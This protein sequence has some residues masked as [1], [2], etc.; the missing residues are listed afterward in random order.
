MWF[1]SQLKQTRTNED[2]LINCSKC[3]PPC[4]CPKWITQKI[5]KP[6]NNV[7]HWIT[8]VVITIVFCFLDHM[9]ISKDLGFIFVL[10]FINK[11]IIVSIVY[12][13]LSLNLLHCTV[14]GFQQLKSTLN[15]NLS[16]LNE[17]QQTVSTKWKLRLQA[18][19]WYLTEI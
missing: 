16:H 10:E 1:N 5:F 18:K 9:D 12:G 17:F 13:I 11:A 8:A 4:T 19:I 7:F 6:L 3:C 14:M 2:H 15:K